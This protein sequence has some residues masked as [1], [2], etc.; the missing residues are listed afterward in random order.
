MAKGKK[1]KVSRPAVTVVKDDAKQAALDAICAQLATKGKTIMRF[2]PANPDDTADVVPVD[3]ISTGVLELDAALRVGGVPRGRVIEIY[4]PESVGKTTL[5]LFVMAVASRTGGVCAFIDAEHTTTPDRMMACG[6][7]SDV[8]ISQPDSGEE[9]MNTL[10]D[11]VRS[12]AI[13]VVVIDSVAALV[14][15]A[16]IDGEV[17]DSH[18]GLQARMMSQTLRKMTAIIAKSRTCVIF[19][20][21][22]RHK[23]GVMFGNPE[24]TT[25]GNALKFYS[26]VRLD[27][28]RIETIKVNDGPV[29]NQLRVKIIKNK[30]APP[31]GQAE[32]ALYFS[33]FERTRAASAVSYGTHLGIL[34][35]AGTWYAYGDERIGQGFENAVSFMLDHPDILDTV[36]AACLDAIRSGITKRQQA[37]DPADTPTGTDDLL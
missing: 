29:G 25:G 32:F 8:L 34:T 17:G 1:D 28:R 35:K 31:F 37:P 14:P 10:E 7:M 3:V 5:A 27:V 20:N 18:M 2:N 22:I 6:I 33:G 11:L 24:T 12:G 4:G 23:I 30:V 13:D 26:S 21:Q 15:Q 16:E 9:A 19:I 36:Y